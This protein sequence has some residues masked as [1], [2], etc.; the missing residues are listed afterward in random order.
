MT[1]RDDVSPTPAETA[2]TAS[3]APTTTQT[4][5][6]TPPASRPWLAHYSPTVAPEIAIP[7]H[8]LSWLLDEASRTFSATTALEYYGTRISYAQLLS[9]AERF[10]R[11][12]VRLGVKPGDRVSLCMPNVPQFPI[13]FFGALKAGAVVVPTNPL[14]TQPELEHQLNDAGVKVVVVVDLLY[15]TLA[16]VRPRTPTVEHVIV[17]GV[18]DYFP[19][20]LA[21]AYAVREAIQNRGK[22]HFDANVFQRDASVHRFKDVIGS[23]HDA[24]GFEVFPLPA[25]AKPDDLALLQYTGGTTGVAKGAMLSHRNLLANAAQCWEWNDM[26]PG[27]KNTSL[28][29]A[30][31]FHV[32]GLTV[33][34]NLSILAGATMVLLPR[35]TVADTLKAIEKYR[36]TLFP[37]V[38]TMYLALAR[39]VEKKP[40]DLSSIQVCI[41]GS[42]PLPAEVQ[43]RF[44]KLS[45]AKVVEGYGLTEASPVTHCN[46]VFGERR[47][48]TIGLPLPN[49]DARIIDPDSW[50]TKPVGEQGEIA[51]AG[52]Q[53][54]QG[55]WNRPDES[56]NVLHDGWLRTG[57][58]GTMSEDG[59]FSIVDRAKDIII[60][61]GYKIFPRDVEEVLYEH[62]KVLEAAVIGMP[63]EY[64]GETVRAYIIPKPGETLTAD[65]LAAFTKER[66]AVYKVPK[67][68][69][70]RETLPKTLVGKVLRRQLREEAIAEMQAHQQAAANQ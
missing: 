1:D 3:N 69:V 60:A 2:P 67:E 46:P 52:P 14:Y 16:A 30:P 13:A 31:F 21:I 29:V 68:Y 35:F 57:D 36:P 11:A 20:P 23:T 26:P 18:S 56:A 34:M 6:P 24:Q 65:E 70:F 9:L 45:G 37:G 49:T 50:E 41:S 54:M 19:R 27:S 59:Y 55:Y 48:G 39:E 58:I 63:D 53:V 66:L 10:A 40:R 42:A 12:L 33:G 62:P 43:R 61:S 64:R 8:A 25:P 51:V 22:P 17:A 7:E 38:P 4:T 32:Y 5:T 47:S 15:N 44:E 28:C